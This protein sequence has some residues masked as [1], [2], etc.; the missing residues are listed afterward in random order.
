MFNCLCFCLLKKLRFKILK[1]RQASLAK[2]ASSVSGGLRAGIRCS[3]TSSGGSGASAAEF[4]TAFLTSAWFGV[5]CCCVF[6][7]FLDRV[8]H[9][10]MCTH[11]RDGRWKIHRREVFGL[12]LGC[13]SVCCCTP[14][15]SMPGGGGC[16]C[17]LCSCSEGSR[18]SDGLRQWR[19]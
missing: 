5:C 16:C 19:L 14:P 8:Y 15:G 9:G 13:A 7:L 11:D 12:L 10:M 1:P 3:I 17:V 18:K 4:I 6:S 2:F